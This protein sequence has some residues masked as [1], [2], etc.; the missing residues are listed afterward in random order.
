MLFG[1][2][3]GDCFAGDFAL[4]EVVR[5]GV[6][7]PTH[8]LVFLFEDTIY[9]VYFSLALHSITHHGVQLVLGMN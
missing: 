6:V 8:V 1:G 7:D 3:I 5:V 9:A 2:Q 4:L